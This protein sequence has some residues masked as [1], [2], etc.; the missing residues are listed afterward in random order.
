MLLSD[1]HPFS[2]LLGGHGAYAEGDNRLGVVRNYHH[3]HGH[4][5]R[6]FRNLGLELL[7]CVEPVWPAGQVGGVMQV[8]GFPQLAEQSVAGLPLVVV[9]KLRR[10]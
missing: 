9:W 6:A 7:E 4:Y 2:V 10:R 5:L 3:S 1:I 8:S